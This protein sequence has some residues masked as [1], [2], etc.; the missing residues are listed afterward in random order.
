MH[1]TAG[2]GKSGR[3]EH[4][5]N[6]ST[7]QEG[8]RMKARGGVSRKDSSVAA[9]G[10]PDDAANSLDDADGPDAVPAST[11]RQPTL[12]DTPVGILGDAANVATTSAKDTARH[13]G[14]TARSGSEHE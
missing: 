8:G 9:A 7:R 11:Q 3:A 10:S 1:Q 2:L 13:M 14:K 12:E 5:N 6:Q 4:V